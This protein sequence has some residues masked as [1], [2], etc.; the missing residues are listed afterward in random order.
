MTSL[1]SFRSF[2]LRLVILTAL[3]TN[4]PVSVA[5]ALVGVRIS[6]SSK[7]MNGRQRRPGSVFQDFPKLL[8]ADH[9]VKRLEIFDGPVGHYVREKMHGI[10]EGLLRFLRPDDTP[11]HVSIPM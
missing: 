7:P 5:E 8:R 4:R 2:R 11:G 6:G 9:A 10:G 1:L 3:A